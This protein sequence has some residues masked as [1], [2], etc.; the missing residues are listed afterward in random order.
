MPADSLAVGLST[1]C[2]PA[3]RLTA[4]PGSLRESPIMT[5]SLIV[6]ETV[7][8]EPRVLDIVLADRLG[9]ALPYDIRKLILRHREELETYGEVFAT[10]AKTTSRGGRPGK[11]YYLNEPQALAI[12]ALSKTPAAA[13]V[14]QALIAAF[15]AYREIKAEKP[16]QVREHR[17]RLPQQSRDL[18]TD[19]LFEGY[20]SFFTAFRDNPEALAEWAIATLAAVNTSLG[21]IMP[22]GFSGRRLR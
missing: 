20:V 21:A 16:V 15:L 10:V 17:R 22:P 19:E 12:C 3:T 18:R 13:K 7:E 6:L 1:R 14:R 9:F 5:N 2:R 11:M 4:A 8:R